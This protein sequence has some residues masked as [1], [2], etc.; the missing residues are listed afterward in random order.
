MPKET[1]P[2]VTPDYD[3]FQ[4]F[5][6]A[7]DEVAAS[8]PIEAQRQIVE[9]IMQ[10]G[11]IDALL[12]ESTAVGARD[13]LDEPLH[14]LGF[15]VAKSDFEDGLQYFAVIDAVTI[16][17]GEK[18]IVTCGATNVLAQLYTAQARGFFPFDARFAEPEKATAAGYKPLWLRKVDTF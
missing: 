8:D 9:R 5:L 3:E 2:A 1:T 7:A 12:G 17:N 16:K 6:A 11:D 14:L 15:R 4:R 18:I 10:A 13:L